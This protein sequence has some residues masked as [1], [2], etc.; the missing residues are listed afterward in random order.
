MFYSTDKVPTGPIVRFSFNEYI[1]ETSSNVF[2]SNNSIEAKIK[3]I[4]Q[5]LGTNF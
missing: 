4:N 3:E 5:I 2:Q 1:P